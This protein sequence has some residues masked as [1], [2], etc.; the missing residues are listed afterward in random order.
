MKRGNEFREQQARWLQ[1]VYKIARILLY[2]RALIHSASP[3]ILKADQEA[4]ETRLRVDGLAGEL[5]E[6]ERAVYG[7][8][9]AALM[10]DAEEIQA[11]IRIAVAA[12]VIARLLPS[13]GNEIRTVGELAE[14]V[15]GEDLG[16]ALEVRRAFDLDGDLRPFVHCTKT[17]LRDEWGVKLTEESLALA[18]GIEPDEEATALVQ[19][20]EVWDPGILMCSP[21]S[22][23]V[24]APRPGS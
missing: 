8:G 7:F 6:L 23:L 19:F 20:K 3:A 4:E 10:L 2:R 12:L 15:G 21:M 18:L 1:A 24:S 13:V 17:L 9:S 11:P 5:A 14:L 22:T 16:A